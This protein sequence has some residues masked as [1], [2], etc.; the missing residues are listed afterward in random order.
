MFIVLS[1]RQIKDNL[2]IFNEI[3]DANKRKAHLENLSFDDI[4]VYELVR[5]D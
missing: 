3:G 4:G 5:K 2:N 1:D